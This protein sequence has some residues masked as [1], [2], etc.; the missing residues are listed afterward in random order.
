MFGRQAT[1]VVSLKDLAEFLQTVM[2]PQQQPQ[3]ASNTITIYIGEL[4][5]HQAPS[6]PQ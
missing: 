1:Q 3:P 2:P 5:I 4:H 6:T